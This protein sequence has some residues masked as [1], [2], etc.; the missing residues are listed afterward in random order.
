M[1]VAS[2]G[3]RAPFL[4]WGEEAGRNRELG[5]ILRGEAVEGRLLSGVLTTTTLGLGD[6]LGGGLFPGADFARL[7]AWAVVAR[8]VVPVIGLIPFK[9][10]IK[11]LGQD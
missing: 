5:W 2:G 10:L 11:Q 8:L 3:D 9:K 6:D 4:V 1:K 7:V